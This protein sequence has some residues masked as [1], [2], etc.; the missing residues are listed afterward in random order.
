MHSHGNLP[1]TQG[2]SERVGAG[3]HHAPNV[4]PHGEFLTC[5]Q[6]IQSVTYLKHSDHL[7]FAIY[8]QVRRKWRTLYDSQPRSFINEPSPVSAAPSKRMRSIHR[9]IAIP[10][11]QRLVQWAM[12]EIARKQ[13]AQLE[14]MRVVGTASTSSSLVA[15]VDSI[16]E[17]DVSGNESDA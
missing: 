3:R 13:Q 14:F 2:C 1:D 16:A 8:M 10:A 5:K 4:L 17:A 11:A 7:F 6:A 12:V 15:E 9:D